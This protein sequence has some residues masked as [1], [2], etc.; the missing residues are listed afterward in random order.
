MS[1]QGRIRLFLDTAD[2]AEWAKWLPTGLFF[3]V[4]TNPVL[5]KAAGV[6]CSHVALQGLVDLAFAHGAKEAQVQ[7]W[8]RTADAY[9]DNGRK[10]AGYSPN[11]VVK[12]PTNDAGV[13]AAKLL[14]SE[15]I[16][17][18]MTAVY[19]PAQA[20]LASALKADYSAPYFGRMN[21]LGRDG[22]GDIVAMQQSVKALDSKTR[23]LVA[24]LRAAGDVAG[25]AAAGLDT[26]TFSPKV[27]A[28]F[29]S[30]EAAAVAIEAFEVAAQGSVFGGEFSAAFQRFGDLP[31][32]PNHPPLPEADKN[33]IMHIEL[34]ILAG[35]VLMGTDAPDSMGFSLVMGNNSHISLEPDTR[36]DTE[37][38]FN[39]LAA[40]G[41]VTMPL[42]DMFWGAYYG[43]LKDKFGVQWMLNCPAKA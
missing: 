40:G 24:S 5:L 34:P 2:S 33:L 42:Q 36:K 20:L 32:M 11:M 9:I 7:S 4:T 12:I 29:F 6:T 22:F 16:R 1:G 41:I 18:T 14:I 37:R 27:A 26:F 17:V 8:G 35:H 30:D 23:I 25:L 19:T 38:L 3:G 13:R 28:D 31:A 21:D 15:N 43:S 10:I 39:A